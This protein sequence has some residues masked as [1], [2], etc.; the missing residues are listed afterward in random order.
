MMR[1]YRFL[2][3]TL[4]SAMLASTAGAL[5]QSGTGGGRAAATAVRTRCTEPPCGRDSTLRASQERLLMRLDSLRWQVENVRL[6]ESERARVTQ[7]MT[8]TVFAL[9]ASLD[10]SRRAAAIA[11]DEVETTTSS[12][13]AMAPRVALGVGRRTRGYLGITFDG[14][15]AECS[16][17][18][19]HVIRFYQYPKIA[20][21]EP[22]SPAERA[23]ILEGDTLLAFNGSD[24][25]SEIS[26]T[27][28][29][30]PRSRI[31]VRVR[32]EGDPMN[33]PVTVGEAPEYYVRRTTP[34]PSRGSIGVATTVT[35]EPSR[36]GTY[37]SR[38][39]VV[40]GPT[41]RAGGT[42]WIVN[43]GVAGAR[44]ETISEGLGKTVGVKEGV[45]VIRAEPGTPAHRSGLRD[46]DVILRAAGRTVATVNALRQ[47]VESSED[48]SI[49]LTILREKKRRELT[50]WW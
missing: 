49:T 31:M 8:Q 21:V 10:Q 1:C 23:G 50:L 3:P 4:A 45:L 48:E 6:S 42:M 14:P 20:M 17:C 44:V 7:E 43:T 25:K 29:L 18:K 35:P 13:S 12:Q 36:P 28:L 5:P 39:M 30:V 46:G 38:P 34:L 32:R 47:A 9:Q 22:D 37:P 40:G 24:V 2:L 15:S 27:K 19:E 16:E 26:L 11:A 33:L 41:P